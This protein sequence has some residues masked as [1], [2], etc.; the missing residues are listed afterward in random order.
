M[1]NDSNDAV[2]VVP[3]GF[4]FAPGRD[5]ATVMASSVDEYYFDTMALTILEGSNFRIEDWTAHRASPSLLTVHQDQ[6][7][8]LSSI[9]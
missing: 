4:Q 8:Q 1:L 5:S 9:N 2:T 6:P 3:E 7:S